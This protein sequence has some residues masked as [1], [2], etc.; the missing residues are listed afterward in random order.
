MALLQC[1]C[2]KIITHSKNFP[3]F[4][5]TTLTLKPMQ[6]SINEFKGYKS[7]FIF[8]DARINELFKLDEVIVVEELNKTYTSSKADRD[9]LLSDILA[10]MENDPKEESGAVRPVV[11]CVIDGQHYN[12]AGIADG[13]TEA[14]PT[15]G[16]ADAALAANN[17]ALSSMIAHAL[18]AIACAVCYFI[19]PIQIVKVVCVPGA[20]LAAVGAVIR[21]R[22]YKKYSAK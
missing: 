3:T 4:V 15:D 12:S 21:L 5:I 11:S 10:F 17:S 1:K 7:Q 9:M 22:N 19:V 16:P 14:A 13:S 6:I 8:I 18:V 2:M 20:L